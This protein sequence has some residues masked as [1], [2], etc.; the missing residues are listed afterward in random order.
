MSIQRVGGYK[1]KSVLDQSYVD[2]LCCAIKRFFDCGFYSTTNY[3]LELTFYGIAE[4]TV[5]T[6]MS[7]EMAY[8]LIT[9][10]ARAQKGI[11]SKN[12]YSLSISHELSRIAAK[13]RATEEAQAK[14]VERDAIAAK[15]KQ[16]E[17]ERPTQ[18][19]RLALFPGL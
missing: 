16:E 17:V 5:A 10:W 14:K 9:E 4:N 1:S 6:A 3:S 12:S 13:E 2:T 8:N 15:A 18:L 11:G 7:F 19:G